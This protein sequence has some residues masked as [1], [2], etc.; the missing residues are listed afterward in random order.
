MFT[1]PCDEGVSLS[2][3]FDNILYSES[4]VLGLLPVCIV[5][6]TCFSGTSTFPG[7]FA[8]PLTPTSS[9]L[10][11]SIEYSATAIFLPLPIFSCERTCTARSDNL[12]NSLTAAASIAPVAAGLTTAK[13]SSAVSLAPV[14]ASISIKTRRSVSSLVVNPP[15]AAPNPTGS[16]SDNP[17]SAITTPAS[18]T[19]NTGLAAQVAAPLVAYCPSKPIASGARAM[20]PAAANNFTALAGSPFGRWSRLARV[21]A[22]VESAILLWRN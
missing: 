2:A 1:T 3:R 15:A 10:R 8:R 6:N 21:L 7:R 4:I 11:P 5:S 18:F 22:L 12:A 16:A 20:I 13:T 17:K 14:F 19:H 9:A